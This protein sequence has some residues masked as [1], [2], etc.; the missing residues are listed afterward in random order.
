MG[1]RGHV[2]GARRGCAA[3]WRES[4]A[5]EFSIVIVNFYRRASTFP[6]GFA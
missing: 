1:W 3:F 4:M 6:R 2:Y 5:A